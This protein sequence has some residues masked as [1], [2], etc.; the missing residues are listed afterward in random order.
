MIATSVI[1]SALQ[2]NGKRKIVWIASLLLCLVFVQKGA[3]GALAV[4]K[5]VDSIQSLK[6][7][8][9][10]S[11][12]FEHIM[13]ESYRSGER[14]GGGNF[15]WI[16]GECKPDGVVWFSA[17]GVSS[18][19]GCWRRQIVN[20]ILTPSDA[21]AACSGRHDD[22][23]AFSR[24]IV[25]AG[26][27][28]LLYIPKSCVVRLT[29]AVNAT[30]SHFHLRIDGVLRQTSLSAKYVIELSGQNQIIDG[31]GIIS[32]VRDEVVRHNDCIK[33]SGS[34]ITIRNIRISSCDY[35]GINTA[36]GNNFFYEQV[37]FDHVRGIAL[38]FNVG[39]DGKDHSDVMISNI[40]VDGS[41]EPVSSQGFAGMIGFIRPLPCRN[42]WRGVTVTNVRGLF[43]V[44]NEANGSNFVG[45]TTRCVTNSAFSAL[46]ITG[47]RLGFSWEHISNSSATGISAYSVF[48]ISNE[49]AAATGF[50]GS[51]WSVDGGALKPASKQVG[52]YI[53]E[54]KGVNRNQFA[55]AGYV[56]NNLFGNAVV[57]V[58]S[59]RVAISSMSVMAASSDPSI[60]IYHSP[61]SNPHSCRSLQ[62]ENS[63][64]DG[65]SLAANL[66]EIRAIAGETTNLNLTIGHSI[67]TG[68]TGAVLSAGVLGTKSTILSGIDISGNRLSGV[69]FANEMPKYL[70]VARFGAANNRGLSLPRGVTRLDYTDYSTSLIEAWIE[71]SP[72]G[73]LRAA[74]GSVVHRV[75]QSGLLCYKTGNM[76]SGWHSAGGG[77]C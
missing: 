31:V 59:S 68:Y 15:D 55:L 40:F 72:N 69:L 6:H 9:E 12:M 2:R 32:S 64:F 11:P 8:G 48:G 13:V 19:S 74:P 28:Y 42:Y 70:V 53:D 1:S 33:V 61:Q 5:I 51:A 45:V 29:F 7:I 34:N 54:D 47:G 30:V 73:V 25:A 20:G 18:A 77:P 56:V 49:I 43:P 63:Y 10:K 50:S 17:T 23:V 14:A 21:G 24:A 44:F 65:A 4:T 37:S 38:E 60:L 52:I 57:C 62:I 76:D 16:S 67:V 66:I 58:T 26:E 71:G 3:N 46:S 22:S 36:G 35:S 39:A 75:D 27:K 41:T